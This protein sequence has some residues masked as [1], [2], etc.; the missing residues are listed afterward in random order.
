MVRM[1][2]GQEMMKNNN[3]DDDDN[4]REKKE[5]NSKLFSIHHAMTHL[6]VPTM[7]IQITIFDT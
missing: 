1:E 3:D 2:D 6:Q 7:S 4:E 5:R